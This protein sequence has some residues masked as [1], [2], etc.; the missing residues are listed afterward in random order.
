M[1]INLVWMHLRNHLLVK[2]WDVNK[3]VGALRTSSRDAGQN[4]TLEHGSRTA[5]A[6]ESI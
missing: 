1:K 6:L 5:D 3:A 2:R 4:I